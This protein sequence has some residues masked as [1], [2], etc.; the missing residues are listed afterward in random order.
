M[1]PRRGFT[2][3][4]LLLAV[5]M[6][7]GIGLGIAGMMSA[8]STGVVEQ[9]DARSS[10][11]RAGMTHAR[12]SAYLSRARCL[13]DLEPTQLVCWLEDVDGDDAIDATEVRWIA[14]DPDTQQMSIDWIIDP[15][16]VLED[17]YGAPTGVDWWQELATLSSHASLKHGTMGLVTGLETWSF[18]HD[19][20]SGPIARREAAM[21]RRAVTATYAL[22]VSG[23]TVEHCMGESIR[24]HDL[25]GGGP[26]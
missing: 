5:G 15:D 7:G 14:W 24:M 21:A 23:V 4:E 9:H 1:T 26:S 11:L 10:M 19:D 2:L 16:V 6:T 22:D 13:L 17:P 18:D 25:P 12:L 8:L 3:L 20:R